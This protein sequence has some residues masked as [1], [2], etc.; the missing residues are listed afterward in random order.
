MLK[1]TVDQASPSPSGLRLGLRVEHT[2]AGWVRFATTFVV[3]DELT[4][5]MR[6]ALTRFLNAA[7]EGRD[8]SLDDHLPLD[9]GS[10]S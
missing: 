7:A 5:E 6:Q 3:Y 9:W 4:N 2:K 1:I 10:D 8:E